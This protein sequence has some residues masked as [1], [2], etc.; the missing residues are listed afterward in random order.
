[1]AISVF[2]L[3]IITALLEYYTN[4]FMIDGFSFHV[5]R[6]IL[7]KE[8]TSIPY[9]RIQ[10]VEIKQGPIYRILGV[11]HV[12][13]STTTDLESPSS[14]RQENDD[15]IIDVIDYSLASLIEKTLT[16]RAEIERMQIQ[17][18]TSPNG[19]ELK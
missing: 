7:S 18:Q 19:P 6:G 14:Q 3:G 4:T 11:G 13:I 12:V 5:V 16:D 2:I 9:R 1:M 8:E 10:A 15:Q 17:K